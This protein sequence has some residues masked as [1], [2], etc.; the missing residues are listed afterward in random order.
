MILF[1]HET[2]LAQLVDLRVVETVFLEHLSG[3]L[4]RIAG[5]TELGLARREDGRS[6][7]D[8]DVLAGRI[9][10]ALE[11]PGVPSLLVILQGGEM[12]A[13]VE[14]EIG[15]ISAEAASAV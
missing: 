10:Y 9:I 7:D 2:L 5:G 3:V 14:R 15:V 6:L 13:E 4:A 8:A 12:L 11:E 1:G